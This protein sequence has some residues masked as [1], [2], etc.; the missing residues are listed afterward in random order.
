MHEKSV[1]LEMEVSR[2]IHLK[3]KWTSLAD[4]LR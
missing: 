1:N 4:S 3:N 2:T